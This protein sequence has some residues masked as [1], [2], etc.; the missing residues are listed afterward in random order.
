MLSEN[1]IDVDV[2][3]VTKV[4]FSVRNNDD[5]AQDISV[6]IDSVNLGD[7]IG[8]WIWFDGHEYD[9]SRTF[10]VFSFEP[11]EKKNIVL[12]LTNDGVFVFNG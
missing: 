7:E 8:N 1:S 2:G 5:F 10:L 4:M 3:S 6:N 12:E 9:A 11:Y